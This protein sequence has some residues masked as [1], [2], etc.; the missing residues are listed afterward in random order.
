M[1]P[2]LAIGAL[3]AAWT[4]S[5]LAVRPADP[6]AVVDNDD[7]ALG[8]A[9]G[10]AQLAP[11][12]TTPALKSALSEFQAGRAESALTFL[13]PAPKEA[14]VKWLKALVLRAAD[15]PGPARK[16]FEQLAQ[17]RLADRAL[18]LAA[19]C[20]I[21]Q[22]DGKGAERLL[23]QVSLRYVDADQVLLEWA[24]QYSRSHVAGP[25]TAERVEEIF[26]PIF[27][28]DVRTDMAP[29]HLIAG[30]AH[31][32]AG[33][34]EKARA[35]YRAAWVDRPLSAAADSARAR[36]RQLGPGAPVPPLQLVK[37]AEI[38]LEAHRNHEAVDQLARIPL[39]SL[40]QGDCPGDRTPA[41]F[42]QAAI[43]ALA[44]DALPVQHEPTAE[45]VAKNPVLPADPLACRARLDQGRAY[46][47][48]HDYARARAALGPVVLRCADPDVR[49]RGLY[50]LAQLETMGGRPTASSLWEAL[51]RKFPQ[52]YLADDALFNQSIALRRAGDGEGE[53][54]LL[55]RLLDEHIDSDL[56]SEAIFHLFWS[57][58]TEGKGRQGLTYLDQLAAH[59]D[60]EGAEEERARYW[61]AR[62]LL[63]PQPDESDL[64]RAAA[65]EAAR[66]DLI[67]LVQERPLTYHGLL[68]RGRL[69]EMDPE[70]ARQIEAEQMQQLAAALQGGKFALHAGALARD[71]HLLAAVELLRMGLRQEASR[72]LTAVDRS[73]ARNAGVEGQEPLALIAELY[74]RAGD[75]RNAHAL[76]R[77]DLR[78]LL[79]RPAS[80]LALRAAALAFPLAFRE[81][82]ARASQSSAIPPDLLQALMREESALDPRALSAT[83][84][85]GLT[86]VMPATARMIARKLKLRGYQTARLYDPETNIR[87]GGAYLGELYARFQHP[88]LAFASYNA[89]PST[90]A[91]WVK[92]RG[93]LPLDQFVEEIPI[94]ET[95]GYVKRCLRS[96]AAYQFLYGNG[97][98]MPLMGQKL[99]VRGVTGRPAP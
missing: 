27:S 62:V 92:A 98:G 83:G 81:Q 8:P 23:G 3:L 34:N 76:M 58:A 41:G 32:A 64:S 4:P 18:H 63:L 73:P 28:G 65:R 68:A 86:Q 52:S 85:L 72:E 45:D 47:K 50:L 61:R 29:A 30:D 78:A 99:A 17:G 37:R 88:A 90:V 96:F 59:P 67:W 22:G 55:R 66:E 49:A 87:I 74:A 19:L 93:S 1:F 48:E 75:F 36:E 89:G 33:E 31:A 51:A 97:R 14:P 53:R 79:R 10:E 5:W 57:L 6:P 21:D 16:L 82:I 2:L 7:P 77:V 91:G 24:R 25:K 38:L 13:P 94:D 46:R 12:F 43:N 20:A 35:H 70:R 80:P 95:R 42:L 54:L 44:P 15:K 9:L 69:A 84:A 39:P 11:W 26:A 71:P 40:C 56:R 60:P